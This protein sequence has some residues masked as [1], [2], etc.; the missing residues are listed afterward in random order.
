LIP[1]SALHKFPEHFL[2]INRDENS[3]AAGEDF[4]LFVQ[5]FGFV[6]VLAA[7]DADFPALD[8]K[9]FVQ[10]HWLQILD[11]HFL[12]EGDDVMQ[13]VHFAHGVV[14]DGGDDASVTV[15]GRSGIALRE[16]ELADEGLAFFVQ[17]KFQVH[18]VGIIGAAGEAVVSFQYDVAGFVTLDLAGHGGD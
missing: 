12:C 8:M 5:D 9:R 4:A 14:E 13:F 2:G 11:R 16:A 3:T 6:D 10:R 18:A 7:V 15:A 1:F 17:D